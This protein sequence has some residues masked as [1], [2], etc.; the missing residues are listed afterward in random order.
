M[1]LNENDIESELSYAYLHAVASKAGL[2]CSI[3]T[4][5]DDNAG[6]D[7]Q[8]MGLGDFGGTITDV[9]L[10]IQLKATRLECKE[11]DGRFPYRLTLEH[12]NVLRSTR[13]ECQCLLVVFFLPDDADEWLTCTEE[14]LAMRKCAYWVSLRGAPPSANTSYQTIYI[15]RKNIL[16]VESLKEVIQKRSYEEY[17]CYAD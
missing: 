1:P 13:R 2:S 9:R 4:R 11:Q 5:L 12:Y 17:I 16:S 7:A 3:S 6:I 8:V 10:D 14:Q 15:P